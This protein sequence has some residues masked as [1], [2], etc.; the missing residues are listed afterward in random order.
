MTRATDVL[1]GRPL[2][3]GGNMSC[4]FTYEAP[5]PENR[6]PEWDDTL[7]RDIPCRFWFRPSIGCTAEQIS[8]QTSC[9]KSPDIPFKVANV[10]EV[11]VESRKAYEI[12]RRLIPPHV[13]CLVRIVPP[14]FPLIPTHAPGSTVFVHFGEPDE[15]ALISL[16]SP[17]GLVVHVDD[18]AEVVPGLVTVF[19]ARSMYTVVPLAM[20]V[21]AG[22]NVLASN[23]G[24]A[25]EYLC[26]YARPGTWH[27]AKTW[28]PTEWKAMVADLHGEEADVQQVSAVDLSPYVKPWRWS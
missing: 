24:A 19:V 28:D 22:S 27:V 1:G 8:R 13:S 21:A 17:R 6:L 5:P 18:F 26:H 9:T 12:A 10:R 7:R 23:A 20:A 11:W 2:F 4:H 15:L 16:I 25:E 14:S 3:F